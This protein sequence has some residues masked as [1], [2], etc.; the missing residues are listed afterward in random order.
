MVELTSHDQHGAAVAW[1]DVQVID[2]EL[3]VLGCEG[4]IKMMRHVAVPRN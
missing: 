2:I 1:K 4:R 3:A